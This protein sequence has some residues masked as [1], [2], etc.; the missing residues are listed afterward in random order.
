V[1]ALRRLLL[2]FAVVAACTAAAAAL[3][4]NKYDVRELPFVEPPP[5][6]PDETLIYVFRERGDLFGLRKFA[7]IDN[8][9]VV[10]VLES[11][12][13]SHFVVPSGQHEVVAYLAPSPLLH[14]RVV[15]S[16]G[17]TVY[18]NCKAGYTSGM[19]MTVLDED[20]AKA[21][22]AKLKYTEIGRKGERAKMDYRAYYD[23]L[24]K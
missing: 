1:N 11:G 22:I 4:D 3:A 19:F 7:M 15:P 16:P 20:A 18:L 23:N 21:L 6:G 13:F 14:Y 8:D 17:R 12:T 10:A 2:A 9:T 24:Y 5:P